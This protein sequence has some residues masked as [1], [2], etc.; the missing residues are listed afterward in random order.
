MSDEDEIKA[1]VDELLR[2]SETLRLESEELKRTAEQIRLDV[3]AIKSK[4]R[5]VTPRP[6]DEQPIRGE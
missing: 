5:V 2:R 4:E 3:E 1:K 6:S